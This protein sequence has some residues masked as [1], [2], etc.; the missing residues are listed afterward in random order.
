MRKEKEREG[1]AGIVREGR[2]D[3]HLRIQIAATE[4]E[5]NGLQYYTNFEVGIVFLALISV[6][7]VPSTLDQ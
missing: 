6:T 3:T 2:R 1:T 5:I 7:R 4:N